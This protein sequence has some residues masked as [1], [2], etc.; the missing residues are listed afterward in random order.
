MKKWDL[1]LPAIP[2]IP[3]F[4]FSFIFSHF[5]IF[6]LPSQKERFPSRV[7][8]MHRI[9]CRTLRGGG[10]HHSRPGKRSRNGKPFL[11]ESLCSLL[12]QTKQVGLVELVASRTRREQLDGKCLWCLSL[13]KL[14]NC[15]FENH[16]C[17]QVSV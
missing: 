5:I 14:Q 10:C 8:R 1:S 6:S 11:L 15:H 9:N 2:A 3:V 13:I 4:P 7:R 16:H 17:A 12:P